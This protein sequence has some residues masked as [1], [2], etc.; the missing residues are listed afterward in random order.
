MTFHCGH[1]RVVSN[2]LPH[3]LYPAGRCRMC[4]ESGDACRG[5]GYWP[6]AVLEVA[7]RPCWNCAALLGADEEQAS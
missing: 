3:D 4:V 2:T 7:G 6:L 5:C 1:P